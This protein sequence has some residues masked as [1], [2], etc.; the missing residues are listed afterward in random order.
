MLFK[1]FLFGCIIEDRSIES[2]AVFLVGARDG[3]A[4]A[5][6]DQFSL[7]LALYLINSSGNDSF[8]KPVRE[9]SIAMRYECMS[10]I[11]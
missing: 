11:V 10:W 5:I 6:D 7:C 3:E 9:D 4:T 1:Y 8:A 2:T